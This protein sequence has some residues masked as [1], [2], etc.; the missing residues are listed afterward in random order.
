ML[1]ALTEAR[2][3]GAIPDRL[4]RRNSPLRGWAGRLKPEDSSAGCAPDRKPGEF[5][6]W[7]PYAH[8]DALPAF[9]TCAYTPV[10][11]RIIADHLHLRER[12]GA[13]ANDGCAP[14]GGRHPAIFDQIGLACGEHEFAGGDI[15]LTATEIDRVQPSFDGLDHFVRLVFPPE[16]DRVGHARHRRVGKRLP[17]PVAGLRHAHEQGLVHRDLKPGNLLRTRDGQVKILDFGL[18][19]LRPEL[20][21]D[22]GL[23]PASG[24]Y[25]T[26]LL[27]PAAVGFGVSAPRTGY[28]TELYR[29][30]S[31][32]NGGGQFGLIH[33]AGV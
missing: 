7:L 18:A 1:A 13:V 20:H 16:H 31:A 4:L 32:G 23:T 11:S 25:T 17:P 3:T 14:H 10:E 19:R 28:G 27:G 2:D 6:G 12:V 22:D 30:P 29:Y 5:K 8:G 15:H 24:V 9:S 21:P 33:G 26:I